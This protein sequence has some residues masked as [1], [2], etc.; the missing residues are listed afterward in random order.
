VVNETGLACRECTLLIEKKLGEW[1][2]VTAP[3]PSYAAFLY[4][5]T[6]TLLARV[7]RAMEHIAPLA[8]AESAWDNVG[9][10]VGKCLEY[11]SPGHV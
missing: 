1:C 11:A 5:L 3:W 6:M 9:L 10:L 2:L 7:L 4:N 8:L